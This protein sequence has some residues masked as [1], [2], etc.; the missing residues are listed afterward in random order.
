METPEIIKP[1][2]KK[3]RKNSV[4]QRLQKKELQLMEVRLYQ[5]QVHA[6][7]LITASNLEKRRNPKPDYVR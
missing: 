2:R 1:K 6:N 3:R 7:V 5:E 4:W